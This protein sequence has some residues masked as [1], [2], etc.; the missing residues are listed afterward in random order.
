MFREMNSLEQ[1]TAILLVEA[2]ESVRWEY[3]ASF[4]G[5]QGPLLEFNTEKLDFQANPSSSLLK[6]I[7]QWPDF[8]LHHNH[9]SGQSLSFSDWRGVSTH[10]NE[11]YAHCN[12]GTSYYGRVLDKRKVLSLINN[13][14]DFI[15]VIAENILFRS[16]NDTQLAGFF[17]KEV[18]CRALKIRGYVEYGYSWGRLSVSN[19]EILGMNIR[20]IQ[21]IGQLGDRYDQM[22]QKAAYELSNDNW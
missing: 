4:Q 15:D 3:S 18:I 12:D 13:K 5:P 22:I 19:Q 8:V 16:T 10:F 6:E 11:I 21:S 9:L 1:K 20:G 2:G 14:R 7:S 17:R